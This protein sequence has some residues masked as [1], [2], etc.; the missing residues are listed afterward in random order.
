MEEKKKTDARNRRCG[1]AR[2]SYTY[3]HFI[4]ERRSGNDRRNDQDVDEDLTKPILLEKDELA[5]SQD[6]SAETKR[7]GSED[8]T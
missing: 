7:S 1:F 6:A 2:R 4:P 5:A 3:S 8:R